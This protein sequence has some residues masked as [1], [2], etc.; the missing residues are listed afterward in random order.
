MEVKPKN[1][2]FKRRV[3]MCQREIAQNR[4]CK[5]CLADKRELLSKKEAETLQE[6]SKKLWVSQ[7]A[8]KLQHKQ[9]VVKKEI[10]KRQVEL[11]G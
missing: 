7:K 10:R 1:G 11:C 6:S 8:P 9:H 4:E 5:K 2:I 3:S